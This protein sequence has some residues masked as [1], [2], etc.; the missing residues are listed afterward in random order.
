MAD[1][2]PWRPP[3]TQQT[4]SNC[5]APFSNT[6]SR[7][8]VLFGASDAARGGAIKDGA[9]HTHKTT[10]AHLCR[11]NIDHREAQFKADNQLRRHQCE[12]ICEPE[13]TILWVFII[14]ACI[15][16]HGHIYDDVW[17]IIHFLGRPQGSIRR[18]WNHK[19]WPLTLD[20]GVMS[21]INLRYRWSAYQHIHPFDPASCLAINNWR[22]LKQQS[23][24][25]GLQMISWGLR[26]SDDRFILYI[27]M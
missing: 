17:C 18:G 20:P 14:S 26:I 4:S 25:G 8:Y 24:F 1:A 12:K 23:T 7:D 5:F 9:K 15:D 21:I 6:L 19:S 22:W 16:L 2:D 13:V 11:S 10:V 3:N 27:Q